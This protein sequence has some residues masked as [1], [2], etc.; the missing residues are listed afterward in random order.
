MSLE[1]LETALGHTFAD[2]DLLERAMT[3]A[4]WANEYGGE[5][6][7]Q[8][9]EYLGDSV[10]NLAISTELFARYS[11]WPEG[12]LSRL[13]S[14]LVCE[15]TLARMAVGLELGKHLKLGRGED[16]SGGRE[17]PSLLAD[18]Y[19]AVLAALYLDGGFPVAQRFVL[20]AFADEIEA[21]SARQNKADFKTRL[22]ELVQATSDLRPRYSIVGTEG[23]PH[24]REFTAEVKVGEEVLGTGL[25]M[26]K[27]AAQQEAARGALDTLAA[28]LT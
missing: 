10:L 2:R 6:D 7:N 16:T 13:R 25:G 18:A 26:S 12:K 20:D 19:E 9:M 5:R 17:K 8:R 23:P 11:D 21:E 4:S 1:Q 15:A 14:Q 24:A 3:H 27:K 22:Q 28:R